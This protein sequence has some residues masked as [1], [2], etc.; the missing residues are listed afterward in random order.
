MDI[1]SK[2]ISKKI[3]E[4]NQLKRVISTSDLESSEFFERNNKSIV[5][6]LIGNEISIIAEHKRKSPSRSEIN[7]QTSTEKIINGYQKAGAV[8]LSILTEKNFFNG[9]N[10]DIT[11]VRK[12][13]E[14]PILRKDFII[15]E[16]QVLE[17]KSIGA[18]GILLIA[19]CLDKKQIIKLSR[20]AKS[21][22]L[23]VL[24]EIH[25]LSEL[26]DCCIESVDIIGVNN[27]NLKTFNVDIETSVSLSSK[28]P[29]NYAKISESGISNSNDIV[30]LKNF[31]YD[32]FLIG[33]NFMK[34]EDP[35]RALENFLNEIKNDC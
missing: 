27:R 32:G 15:D 6:G 19:A 8:A 29:S 28:I 18:D 12:I 20:L 34:T 35:G 2:I 23:E 16:F 30:T 1:L 14:L 9:S 10:Y 17:S 22:D 24:I 3:D 33:E 31:G 26:D 25:D 5:S 11:N 13:T 21:L 7:F 4:L